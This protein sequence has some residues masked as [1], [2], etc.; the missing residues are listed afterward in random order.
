MLKENKMGVMPI[1][2]LVITMS[3]PMMVSMLVQAL[4]NVVDSIF[5]SKICEDALTAVSLAFPAQNLMIGVATGTGVGVNALLSRYLGAREHGKANSVAANGVLLCFVS[6]AI[7]LLF[8]LFGVNLFYSSQ[9]SSDSPIFSY[10][11]DY[12]S[13]ICILSL[14]LFG[15][16]TM[17][18]LMQATGKTTLSMVTQLAGAIT[19]II[20][21]PIFIFGKGDIVFGDFAMPF[22]LGLE[23]KGAAFATVIGQFVAFAMGCILQVKLNKEIKISFKGF[24]PDFR[25]ILEIYKIG[26]PSILMVGIG[27]FMT[28]CLNKILLAFT[29]TAAAVFGVYF[30]LQSFVFMPVFGLN[31]GVIP[32]IAFNYGAR[33]KDRILKTVR[34]SCVIAVS[35]MAFGTLLMWLMP[36]TMLRLFDASDDMMTIGV[37]ALE[38]ISTSF[39]LAGVSINLGAVFM[40]FGKSYFSTIVSFTRQIV[41]LLP[42]AYLLAKTGNVTNVW[43][44]FP[45]AELFSLAVTLASFIFVYK[46]IIAKISKEKQA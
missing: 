46:T 3:L 13:V 8:G 45:I 25:L 1:K 44:A 27:S 31:N 10:G 33:N 36:E 5:V 15:Q 2:K 28:F 24:R 14:G 7:F 16:V 34:F 40:A 37:P 6:G 9:V 22:G 43:F 20:L 38:I 42:A 18:R 35:V 39:I 4:Y 30:K 11:V 17:E 12:L 23:A 19:N 29:S 26:I 32:I 21:D 41:V